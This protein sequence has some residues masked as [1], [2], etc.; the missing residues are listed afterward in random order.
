M[1]PKTLREILEEHPEWV[2]LPVGVYR[3]DGGIDFVGCS[4]M[5]YLGHEYDDDENQVG[6]VVLFANN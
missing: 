2:D 1:E 5:V 3:V 4:G 6:D